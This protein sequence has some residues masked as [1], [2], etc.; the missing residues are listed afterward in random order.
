MENEMRKEIDRLK[1]W[2]QFLNENM[3]ISQTYTMYIGV[4]REV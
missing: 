1:N 3:D 4:S 2:K